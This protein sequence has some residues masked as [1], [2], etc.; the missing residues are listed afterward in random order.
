MAKVPKGMGK[1]SGKSLPNRQQNASWGSWQPKP[2]LMERK[3]QSHHDKMLHQ[4]ALVAEKTPTPAP[5]PK[6]KAKA[7]SR[8]KPPQSGQLTMEWR[9][10]GALAGVVPV[11]QFH[12]RVEEIRGYHVEEAT[13]AGINNLIIYFAPGNAC[14]CVRTTPSGAFPFS[15]YNRETGYINWNAVDTHSEGAPS[16]PIT[17]TEVEPYPD[18]LLSNQVRILRSAFRIKVV[19]PPEA[20][21]TFNWVHMSDADYAMNA[22]DLLQKYKHSPYRNRVT[23]RSN[24]WITIKAPIRDFYEMRKWSTQQ[25]FPTISD[26]LI[27]SFCWL[28]EVSAPTTDWIAA[29]VVHLE[30]VS[31]VDC[32]LDPSLKHHAN[33]KPGQGYGGGKE[34]KGGG[35]G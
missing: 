16:G 20:M 26:P 2:S 1:G 7:R 10:F 24:V 27:A 29:P 31:Y 23:M 14:G 19:F 3:F 12:H 17:S 28:S 21:L 25:S 9:P 6:A 11:E 8:G 34:P 30:F 5:R 13:Y 4:L 35:N 18:M 15:G 22:E 32:R 33:I